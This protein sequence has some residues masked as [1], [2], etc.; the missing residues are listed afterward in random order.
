LE[1][2]RFLKDRELLRQLEVNELTRYGNACKLLK[3]EIRGR[4]ES[5]RDMIREMKEI[6]EMMGQ[7]SS[8]A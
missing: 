1:I 4:S 2:E 3:E 5:V 7:G 8:S 6:K